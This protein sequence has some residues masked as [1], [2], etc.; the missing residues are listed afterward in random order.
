MNKRSSIQNIFSKIIFFMPHNSPFTLR[1]TPFL[2]V[3]IYFGFSLF[4][5]LFFIDSAWSDTIIFTHGNKL[6]VKGY[7][8]QNNYITL[9]ITDSNEI[10]VPLDWIKE[11]KIELEPIQE[12]PDDKDTNNYQTPFLDI[13]KTY[14]KETSIDWQLLYALIKIESA[15]N[16]KAISPKGAMGLM[17]LM[18][19]TAELYNVKNPYDPEDN[20]RAGSKHFKDLLTFYNNNLALALA[21]YNAGKENVKS[22]NGIPPFNETQQYVKKILSYYNAMKKEN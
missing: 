20:V 15:F 18:P 14:A 2:P 5:L 1:Q 21:A 4:V 3:I 19:G 17:Q 11:I 12:E 13:I 16:P 10:T 9:K 22:Y 6:K 7:S 8:I